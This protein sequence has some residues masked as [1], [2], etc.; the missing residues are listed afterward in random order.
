MANKMMRAIHP[1]KK[2]IMDDC[3]IQKLSLNWEKTPRVKIAKIET[4]S[5]NRLRK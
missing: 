5:S 3:A 4:A 2:M 1:V